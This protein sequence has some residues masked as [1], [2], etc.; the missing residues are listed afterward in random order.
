MEIFVSSDEQILFTD[1][2]A[3]YDDEQMIVF[4]EATEGTELSNHPM[5]KKQFDKLKI[6]ILMMVPPHGFEPRT[7]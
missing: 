3:K 1:K 4:L 2:N 7:Y 5:V 6:L